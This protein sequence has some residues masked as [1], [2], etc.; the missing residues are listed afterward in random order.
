MMI[1]LSILEYEHELSKYIDNLAQSKALSKMFQL[2]E[3]SKVHMLHIDVMRPPMIPDKTSFSVELIR[4][5]YETLHKRIPLAIHLMVK[6]PFPIVNEINEFIT[7]K[8][9]RKIIV[10]IQ[11]E[12]FN[13]EEDTVKSIA[14]LKKYGYKAGVCLDLPTPQKTLRD[15]IVEAADIVLLMSV[16]MGKGGQRYSSKATRRIAYLNR[17]IPNITIEVDGGINPQT[18]VIAAKA[19]AKIAVVGSYITLSKDPVKAIYEIDANLKR[20]QV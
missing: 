17:R 20:A 12:S 13:S 6:D 9:R 15:R 19:G 3:T 7:K 11:V 18:I 1:S 14:L 2:I 4:R 8:E 16:P 10:F 5:L